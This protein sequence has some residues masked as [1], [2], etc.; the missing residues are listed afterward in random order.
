L[1]APDVPRAAGALR[2]RYDGGIGTLRSNSVRMFVRSETDDYVYVSGCVD[3]PD[4]DGIWDIDVG[5]HV[6]EGISLPAELGVD[7]ASPQ[8]TVNLYRYEDG[9]EPRRA[10][11]PAS[12]DVE[13]SGMLARFDA[14]EALEFDAV[15]TK[16]CDGSCR[17]Q[18]SE[19]ELSARLSW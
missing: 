4:V 2:I 7:D 1:P 18:R 19:V 9:R 17:A 11:F 6:P 5:A 14:G 10:E 15:L 16:P 12:S 13:A 3:D 8:L